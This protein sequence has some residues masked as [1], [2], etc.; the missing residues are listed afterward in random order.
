LP[1]VWIAT[2]FA[3]LE[4]GPNDVVV[5]PGSQGGLATSFRALVGEGRPLLMESPTYWGAILAAAQ[6]RGRA[7]QLEEVV[8][9]IL[10]T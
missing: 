4:P 10:Q 6:E 2:P 5:L 3:V 8:A 7:R 1:S 9:E